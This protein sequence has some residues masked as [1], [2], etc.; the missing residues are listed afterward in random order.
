MQK[1]KVMDAANSYWTVITREVLIGGQRM[2]DDY[3][4]LNQDKGTILDSGTTYVILPSAGQAAFDR[5]I[6]ATNRSLPLPSS[7]GFSPFSC[8][9]DDVA[10]LPSFSFVLE[11]TDGAIVSLPFPP[12][13]YVMRS[14]EDSSCYYTVFFSDAVKGTILGQNFMQGTNFYFDRERNEVRAAEASCPPAP[15]LQLALRRGK[16]NKEQQAPKSVMVV[17]PPPSSAMIAKEG[18]LASSEESLSPSSH[19]S[20]SFSGWWALVPVVVVGGLLIAVVAVYRRRKR[21]T[22]EE[23]D[24]EDDVLLGFDGN[25]ASF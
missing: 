25:Y 2:Y 24:E 22:G 20:S 5:A 17:A 9:D 3:S 4:V 6:K 11:G 15:S 8:S 23:T 14:K 19:P 10:A 13:K 12:Q 7:I 21:A 1:L 18:D 16:D